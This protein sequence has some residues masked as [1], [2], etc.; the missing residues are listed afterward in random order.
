M[1]IDEYRQFRLLTEISS[2]DSVTQRHLAHKYG[3]ALGLTNFLL[4]RLVNKGY[5]KII[6]LKRNRLRYLLTP[7]GLA[8]KA[9]LTYQYFEYSLAL[10][11]HIR[12]LMTD[13]FVRMMRVGET[14]VIIYG[15]GE[16]AE[17]AVLAMQ[18]RGLQVVAAL[19]EPGNGKTTFMNQ[20]VRSLAA[21]SGL[22]FDWMVIATFKNT[23]K[24][25]QQLHQLEVPA[26]KIIVLL[27]QSVPRLSDVVAT[28]VL[29]KPELV[30]AADSR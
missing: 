28:Q 16:L 18:E 11:R 13:T 7:K 12:T 19:E 23:R 21:L 24:I 6:N 9:R 27:D 29:E 20:P 5:V 25:L 3:L 10:Y 4:H 1:D 8:E 26:T 30:V 17:I 22:E 2:G 15:T 14:R